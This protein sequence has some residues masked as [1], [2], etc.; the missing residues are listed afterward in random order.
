VGDFKSTEELAEVDEDMAQ[1]WSDCSGMTS[2]EAQYEY[3]CIVRRISEPSLAPNSLSVDESNL[4]ATIHDKIR[5]GAV[6]IDLHGLSPDKADSNG[7]TF[8]HVAV[9]AGNLPIA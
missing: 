4:I 3:I 5:C 7:T 6:S 9:D 2:G 8:L 1:A